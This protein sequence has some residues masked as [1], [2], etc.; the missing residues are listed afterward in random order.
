[1]GSSSRTQLGSS[2]KPETLYS[3]PESAA[4][5]PDNLIM[6][7]EIPATRPEPPPTIKPVAPVTEAERQSGVRAG[8]VKLNET[9]AAWEE[10]KKARSKLEKEE[11]SEL[12]KKRAKALAKFRNEMEY[13]KEVADGARAEAKARQRNDELKAKGKANIIRT[14]GELPVTCFCC[15]I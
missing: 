6:K 13:I 9:I 2:Q 14:T 1:M 10:K 12:E 3:Q 4:S 11:K 15:Q 8:Y 5:K 7:P